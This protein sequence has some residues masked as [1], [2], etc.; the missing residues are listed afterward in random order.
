MAA[1]DFDPEDWNFLPPLLDAELPT[2]PPPERDSWAGVV[3]GSELGSV[4]VGGQ[5]PGPA[6]DLGPSVFEG[7]AALAPGLTEIARLGSI[8]LDGL[9]APGRVDALIA[10][11]R[12]QAWLAAREQELLALISTRDRSSDR[13]CVEE[14][15]AALAMSSGQARTRLAHAEQLA[16]RL[17]RT[18]EA[19][20]DGVLTPQQADAVVKASFVLPD[21]LLPAYEARVLRNAGEQSTTGLARTAQRA[22]HALDPATVRQQTERSIAERHV[23]IAPA[24]LGTAWLMALLPAADA[25]AVYTRLDG[26]ARSAPRED[27]RSL[28]QLRADALVTGLLA[29]VGTAAMPTEQG[30]E[31]SIQ[32]TVGLDTLTGLDEQPGWLD[33]YGPISA[34]YA[35]ELAHDPTGTWR[36]LITDPA[37]GQLMDYGATRYRPPRHLA[38]HVIARDG[39]CAFPFCTHQAR[40]SDLDHIR[41]YPAGPTA[42]DNLQPLH[43]RHHNAKTRAGWLNQRDPTT[44][45]THWISPHG[46]HYTSRPPQRWPLPDDRLPTDRLPTDRLPADDP[47]AEHPPDQHPSGKYP[48]TEHPPDAHP[49]P[50]ERPDR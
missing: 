50:D 11:R 15:G 40:R 12:Q 7:L 14:V 45:D 47:P 17:P 41:P 28:D 43:R 39:E 19:L 23:R 38:E 49:P 34:D 8:E 18:F 22:A 6:T 10:V 2:G 42:A 25:Q 35:R 46:R 5:D 29:G 32:V 33:N 21:G 36:R 3:V 26:A 24:G 20:S 44:G 31:P 30:R 27:P 4:T 37:S 16:A 1:P 9:D 13:W 48:P